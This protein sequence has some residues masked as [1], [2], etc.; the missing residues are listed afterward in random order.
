MDGRDARSGPRRRSPERFVR[1]PRRNQIRPGAADVQLSMI[2]AWYRD[3]FGGND[4][5]VREFVGRY[6]ADP[7]R[8]FLHDQRPPIEYLDYDWTMNAQAG[9]RPQ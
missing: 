7:E 5:A 4:E 3:D 1:D 8:A 6:S 9:Q 2:F